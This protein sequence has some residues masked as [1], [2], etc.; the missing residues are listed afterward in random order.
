[1]SWCLS[2]T[3]H[4]VAGM[5]SRAARVSVFHLWPQVPAGLAL[6]GGLARLAADRFTFVADA[7]ALVGLGLAERSDVRGDLTDQLL[8]GAAHLDAGGRRHGERH[9]LGRVDLNRVA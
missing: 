8:V 6:A 2:V 7:L 5:R 4:P 9:A 3:P 1:M